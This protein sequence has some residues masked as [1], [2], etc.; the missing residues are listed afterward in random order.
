M[1]QVGPNEVIARYLKHAGAG[2]HHPEMFSGFL[3]VEEIPNYDGIIT[4]NIIGASCVYNANSQSAEASIA[5]GDAKCSLPL[6]SCTLRFAFIQLELRRLTFLVAARNIQS[7]ALVEKLG[8]LPEATLRDGADEGD[9]L[10]YCLRP[11]TCILWS[12]LN[13]QR[14]RRSGGT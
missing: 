8:A 5:I 10:I 7:I 3:A 14:Q 1:I 13:G 11:E 4:P 12:R 9:M 2:S 6:I